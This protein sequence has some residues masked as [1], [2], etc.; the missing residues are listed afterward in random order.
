MPR[1]GRP[2]QH[3]H[4][5]GE[6]RTM[7]IGLEAKIIRY[8]MADDID[9]MFETGQI[10]TNR[11]YDHFRTGS[12]C[13]PPKV[14]IIEDYAKITNYNTPDN[15]AFLIDIEDIPIFQDVRC[16]IDACGYVIYKQGDKTKKVH[17]VVMGEP[18]NMDIDHKD[19]NKSD[20]RKKNLRI[21]NSSENTMNQKR[22]RTNKSGYKGVFWKESNNKYE[23]GIGLDGKRIYLGLFETIDEAAKAYNEAALKYHGEFA[24]LNI[25]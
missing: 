2:V 15:D 22:R 9:V 4:R 6:V 11:K 18:L 24:R 21:C 17:R 8:R 3:R 23:V 1:T 19:G 25:I 7:K 14:E 12:I 13:C 16:H 5:L 20:C 10:V